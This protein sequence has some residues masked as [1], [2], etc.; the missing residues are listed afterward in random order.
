MGGTGDPLD[1]GTLSGLADDLGG[2]EALRALI[3]VYLDQLDQLGGEIERAAAAGDCA[4]V[5]RAAHQLKSSTAL[6]GATALAELSRQLETAGRS[7]ETATVR[8]LTTRLPP[9]RDAAR[10]ALA[11]ELEGA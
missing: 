10:A 8:H 9:A 11:A 6:L 2:R 7:D 5:A 4:A 1:A 3:R